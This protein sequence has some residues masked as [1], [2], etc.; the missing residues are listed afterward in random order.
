MENKEYTKLV[1]YKE[2]G[3]VRFMVCLIMAKGASFICRKIIRLG[4]G[5]VNLTIHQVPLISN[6]IDSPD[7]PVKWD[8]W[9]AM[10]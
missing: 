1:I 7:N 4:A 9:K 10:K 3:K 2:T 5:R 8:R 6:S